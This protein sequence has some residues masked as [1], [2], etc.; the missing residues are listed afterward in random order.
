MAAKACRRCTLS[1]LV[2][3]Y[4]LNVLCGRSDHDHSLDILVPAGGVKV[5]SNG[6]V[7]F[8]QSLCLQN[9]GSFGHW[10]NERLDLK[11]CPENTFCDGS[12]QE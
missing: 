3:Y 2:S 5:A 4:D 9:C 1:N 6:R 10:D 7:G 8:S 11:E 12:R